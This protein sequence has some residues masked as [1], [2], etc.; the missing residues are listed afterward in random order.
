MRTRL[1][2]L[3]A[4]VALLAGLAAADRADAATLIVDTLLDVEVLD[5]HCSL[6][7]ALIAAGNDAPWRDCP[8][9]SGIDTIKIDVSGT[10]ELGGDLP[11]LVGDGV[12]LD[13][14]GLL[15]TVIDGDGQHRMFVVEAGEVNFVFGLRALTLRNGRATEN[16]GCVAFGEA[17]SDSLFVALRVRFEGCRTDGDGG[18]IWLGWIRV[19]EIVESWLVGNQ[20]A[21]HGGAVRADGSWDLLLRDS[22]ISGNRAGTGQ[23]SGSGGGL[24]VAFTR[25]QV[26]RSTFSENLALANGGGL[27]ISSSTATLSRVIDSTI[28][29]NRSGVEGSSGSAGGG[30]ALAAAAELEITNSIVA[31]N[32][33]DALGVPDDLLDGPSA[34]FSSEGF[35]WIGVNRNVTDAFPAPPTPGVPNIHGDWVGTS[36]APL[37]PGL[38]P[39]ANYGGRT[40]THRPVPGSP[41]LD[42]GSCPSAARDQRGYSDPDTSLRPYDDPKL[43]D[44]FDGCDIGSVEFHPADL[45]G[46]PMPFLDGFE[47]GDT[48]AWSLV[49]P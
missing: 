23:V 37:D 15:D 18:A 30:I 27:H 6:R 46:D 21:G 7:E 1:R 22:T 26:E 17:G 29:G 45:P 47:S 33:Q 24:L 13:G 41:V 12:L 36:A 8:A 49:A 14:Q 19:G 39:L 35:N 2:G 44:G 38:E 10:I 25:L 42:L 32:F 11:P 4:A 16:G 34:V 5:G 20:A 40:P 43:P 3:L 9:G 28:V 48:E 31:L